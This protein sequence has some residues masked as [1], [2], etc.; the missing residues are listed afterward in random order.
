MIH[1]NTDGIRNSVLKELEELYKINVPKYSVCTEDM[2]NIISRLSSQIEREI[3]VGINRKGK[4]IS[5][6]IGDS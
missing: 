4:V 3:S 2:I 1:G 5:V 6:A